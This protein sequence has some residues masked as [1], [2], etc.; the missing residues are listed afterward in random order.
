MF[1]HW[2][3]SFETGQMLVDTE[4]RLLVFL[5]RKLDVAI[6]TGQSQKVVNQVIGELKRYVEFHF[7]SEE[8]VM[9]E[10]GYPHLV[11]HQEIHHQLLAELGLFESKLAA[12]KEFPEDL[13][14][15]LN[16]WLFD[17]IAKH[18]QH[19]ARHVSDS[20]DRPIAEYAYAEY[21]TGA[22]K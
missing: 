4:H 2:D 11:T 15:F 14:F 22:P 16:Q 19:V 20:V 6:K 1:I 18:D 7:A 5:F 12:R 17:H 8:N 10:T 3:S 9:R 21:L 13:L